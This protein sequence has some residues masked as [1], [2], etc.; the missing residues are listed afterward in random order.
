MSLFHGNYKAISN[1]PALKQ[2]DNIRINDFSLHGKEI[3][4]GQLYG[5][6]FSVAIRF[7]QTNAEIVQERIQALRQHGFINFYGMQRFGTADIQTHEVGRA[8]L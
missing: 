2:L 5:N 3:A 1:H 8:L 4:L 6:R 7:V